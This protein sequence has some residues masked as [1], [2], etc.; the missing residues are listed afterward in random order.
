[1]I[2]AMMQSITT[3]SSAPLALITLGIPAEARVQDRFHIKQ[4]AI[5]YVETACLMPLAL[6][7]S[8]ATVLT[9]YTITFAFLI[10]LAA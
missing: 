4:A 6:P 8:P 5:I 1:M 2:S 9:T 10:V 7:A 3:V